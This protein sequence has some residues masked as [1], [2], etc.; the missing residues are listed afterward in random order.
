MG[1]V[2][3]ARVGRRRTDVVVYDGLLVLASR[4]APDSLPSGQLAAQDGDSRILDAASV[5]DVVVRED[6]LSGKATI[7]QRNGNEIVVAWPG[8]KNRGFSAENLLA[9]AFPGTVDQGPD[10]RVRRTARG[11]ALAG[12]VILVLVAA[13]IGLSVLLEGDPPPPPPAAP[14]VTVAPAEQSARDELNAACPPWQLYAASVGPGDRPVPGEMR[15]IVD[16]IR[17]RFD[18]AAGVAGVDP[19]YATARDELAY[20]QDYARRP[21]DAVQLESVSR[22]A[23]ALRTVSAACARAASAP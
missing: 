15:P 23:F 8:R 19:A 2:R 17:G 4:G 11:M 13:W 9:H 1:V 22:V 16:G 20:L 21:P 5:V 3:G 7:R 14:P 6:A 10:E 12:F 18:A